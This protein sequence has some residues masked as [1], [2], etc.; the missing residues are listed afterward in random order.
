MDELEQIAGFILSGGRPGADAFMRDTE[1]SAEEAFQR[2]RRENIA[3]M[4]AGN[5][6]FANLGRSRRGSGLFGNDRSS[7][8]GQFGTTIVGL[9][10]SIFD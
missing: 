1:Q 8:R 9:L 3:A 5:P 2:A 10:N 7:G 6:N 4:H